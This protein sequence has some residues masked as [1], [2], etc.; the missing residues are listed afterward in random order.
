VN[1]SI[2]DLL[3]AINYWSTKHAATGPKDLKNTVSIPKHPNAKSKRGTGFG[4]DQRD[5]RKSQD[6][7]HAIE[8]E[9]D[10]KLSFIFRGISMLL[11]DSYEI[12]L[13]CDRIKESSELIAVV[14]ALWKNDSLMDI[15]SRTILYQSLSELMSAM[16]AEPLLLSS[17]FK[18]HPHCGSAS[19]ASLISALN[20]Q[21]TIFL[22]FHQRTDEQQDQ[23]GT[24]VEEALLIALHIQHLHLSIQK[25]KPFADEMMHVRDS[26]ESE[27]D[28]KKARKDGRDDE[29]SVATT[30]C[31]SSSVKQSSSFPSPAPSSAS[32]SSS[33]SSSSSPPTG[34]ESWKV[35]E[36]KEYGDVLQPMRF[37]AISLCDMITAGT[38]S[39]AILNKKSNYHGGSTHSSPSDASMYLSKSSG[40]AGVVGNPRSRL[41]RI[42]SEMSSLAASL[43]VEHSAA[44]FLRCDEAR[45]DVL[46]ALVIGPEGTPY[47]NGCFEFDIMLSPDYPNSPPSV[48]LVTTG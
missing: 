34:E 16:V 37:E 35:D 44:I 24:E 3:I 22:N 4:G 17:I 2:D 21:V 39:H 1:I 11:R 38:A 12:S 40:H 14:S 46:K 15:A 27:N 33:S 9:L 7:S 19:I 47:A 10:R 28:H 43:P 42:A 48:L 18:A 6:K 30:G 26:S 32:S 25:A 5:S 45:M 31:D 20:D 23:L 8:I 13:V 36:A 29:N 41:T